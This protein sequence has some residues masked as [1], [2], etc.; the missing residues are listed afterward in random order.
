M[1]KYVG[2]GNGKNVVDFEVCP[3]C[4][5]PI[6]STMKPHNDEVKVIGYV[7]LEGFCYGNCEK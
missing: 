7:G 4:N 5:K 6:I 2:A 3:N 1:A